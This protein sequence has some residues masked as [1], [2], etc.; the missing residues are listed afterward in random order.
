MTADPWLIADPIAASL[1]RSG[2]SD[3]DAYEAC[4]RVGI[5][6]QGR[7]ANGM[8]DAFIA[9]RVINEIKTRK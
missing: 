3:E 1:L 2:A 6:R 9:N 7:P 5:E 8:A 4:E